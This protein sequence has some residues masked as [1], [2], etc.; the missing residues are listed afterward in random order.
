MTGE[1]DGGPLAGLC[2]IDLST[3][4]TGPYAG[5][6]FVDAGADVV[7]V[8][9]PDGDPLRRWTASGRTLPAGESGA[10]F[11]YLNAGKRG[12]VADL[13]SDAGRDLVLGLADRA[14]IVLESFGPGGAGA[15][16]IGWAAVHAR[17]PRCSVVSISPFGADGPFSERPSTEFTLQAA[18]GS[19]AHRG[20]P[21]RGPVGAGGRIGDWI[22]GAYAAIGGLSAWLSARR[23]GQGQQVDLSCFECLCLC[24]TI[25]HDLNSQ[26][27]D[28]PLHQAIETPSIEPAKDGWVGLCTITGQQWKDFCSLIGQTEVAEDERFYDAKAR[29]EHL[30][31]I[32]GI[33]HAYTRERTV[34]EIVETLSLARIPVNPLGDGRT[35]LEM[36]HLRERGVFVENP[37]GFQQPRPPYRLGSR[38]GAAPEVKPA[39]EIGQHQSEIEREV[40]APP[41]QHPDPEGGSALPYEGLRVLDLTAFWAGPVGTSFLAELGADVIKLESTQRP[42]FMRLAG[43]VRNETMWEFNPIFHGCNSS[44]RDVTLHLD[45]DE[46]MAL[47]RRLIA[48]ADVVVENFSPRVLE[49]WDLG[50]ETIHALNPRTLLVRM[51]SFG[52]DGPWRDRV[53]FAMN[54]EQVS[55]LAWLTGYDDLPLVV[56]GACDPLGGMH[57]V[58]ALSLALEER[59][60]TGL[61]Q[62]VEVPLLEPAINVAAE[63]VIEW[64]AYGAF[65]ER[66]QNRSP[67]AAPQGVYPC[68]DRDETG[69]GPGWVAI[70]VA[71]D[72]QWQ[73]LVR[74]LGGPDWSRD[75][76]LSS[77]AGRR[78]VHDRIDDALRA[79]TGTHTRAEAAETLRAAGVPAEECINP[80]ALF[81][82]PQLEHRGFFQVMAHPLVGEVRYPGQP[83]RFSGL[84]RALRRAP[85]PLLGEHNE[86]VLREELGLSESE[87]EK[88]R[89]TG[90]IGTRPAFM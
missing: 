12:A 35:L 29:M 15:R 20:L 67:Q 30:E 74:V 80:H 85:A 37:A 52:L 66:E 25:Y 39:P 45:S 82:N 14:D 10:L 7:K 64:S 83:M 4:I 63:Q 42:D 86:E 8:E 16:G 23:T 5:K 46:G 75:A 71:T 2:V 18:T 81:P 88:L 41:P 65:L 58:F 33:I 87:I 19:V 21:S 68:A 84:P 56:R 57:A 77:S 22:P 47:A 1:P 90:V 34:E 55:G 24:L 76:A 51:P 31:F 44:K 26:F 36:D 28:G 60:R 50:W 40:A 79:W 17:N 72:D 61:G 89:E 78:A 59:R 43:S 48:K 49:N 3:E 32:H 73:A 54:I 13:D 38:G 69:D 53:G 62:L 70:A 6:L 9:A 27:F 11:H